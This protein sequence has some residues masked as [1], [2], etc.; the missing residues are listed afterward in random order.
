MPT[1]RVERN[2]LP[3]ISQRDIVKS[4]YGKAIIIG[5]QHHY[6]LRLQHLIGSP[7]PG[8]SVYKQQW[9]H[10]QKEKTSNKAGGPANKLTSPT[11][12]LHRYGVE[13]KKAGKK[14]ADWPTW[15]TAAGPERREGSLNSS[16]FGSAG[17]K[18]DEWQKHNSR[19]EEVCQ[20]WRRWEWAKEEE[21]ECKQ[22]C[23]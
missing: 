21:T 19:T 8:R 16:T 6:H 13:E 22:N 23:D 9:Q 12:Y 20:S 7:G 10:K 3:S 14:D 17:P 5:I 11:T 1:I 15:R 2:C 4:I 18:Q